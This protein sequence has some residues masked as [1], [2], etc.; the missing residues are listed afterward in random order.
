MTLHFNGSKT[1][2]KAPKIRFIQNTT[3]NIPDLPSNPTLKNSTETIS[4]SSNS[5]AITLGEL[6]THIA[7]KFLLFQRC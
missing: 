7:Q 3:E 6:M 5:W 4:D 1:V 2:Q